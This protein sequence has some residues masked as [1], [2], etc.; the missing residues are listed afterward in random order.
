M[1]HV[2]REMQDLMKRCARLGWEVSTTTS[3]HFRVKPPAGEVLHFGGAGSDPRAIHNIKAKLRGAGFDEAEASYIEGRRARGIQE[4]TEMKEPTNGTAPATTTMTMKGA[5]EHT[6][7][8]IRFGRLVGKFGQAVTV[9]QL[10]E[11]ARILGA[12]DDLGLTLLDAK[13]AVLEVLGERREADRPQ[14]NKR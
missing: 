14:G 13:A 4:E 7:G 6:L 2:S 10:D 8:I 12:A 3:G 5:D 11:I 9:E 1:A